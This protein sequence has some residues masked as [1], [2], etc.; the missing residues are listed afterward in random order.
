MSEPVKATRAQLDVTGLH[1]ALTAALRHGA[2]TA[3]IA[4]YTPQLVEILY[5]G[6][7]IN[8]RYLAA[9]EDAIRAAVDSIG[10]A[11]ADALSTLLGLAPGTLG[12]PLCDRRAVAARTLG[13]EPDT[14]RRTH[15]RSL[16]WDLAME[17]YRARPPAPPEPIAPR[18]PHDHNT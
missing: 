1:T 10:G 12:M 17:I 18:H 16:L 13:I 14:M 7:E 3:R 5:P 4:H 8:A 11:E 9:V 15:Q 6:G 2:R